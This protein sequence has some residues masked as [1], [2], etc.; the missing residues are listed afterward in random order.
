MWC[1]MLNVVKSF[2][3]MTPSVGPAKGGTLS[4]LLGHKA[5]PV[6]WG[7]GGAGMGAA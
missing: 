2:E 6:M 5:S 3:S 7:Q 1:F 4:G